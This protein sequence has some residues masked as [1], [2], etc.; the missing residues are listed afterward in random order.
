MPAK[1]DEFDRNAVIAIQGG[2]VY[3]LGLLGQLSALVERR[4]IVPLAL[5][6]TSA[7]AILATL[8]WAGLTPKEIR[9]R[10]VELAVDG[11]TRPGGRETLTDLLGP[12]EPARRPF[13]FAR[14]RALAGRIERLSGP[15]TAGRDPGEDRTPRTGVGRAAWAATRPIR[16]VRGVVARAARWSR[17]FFNLVAVLLAVWPHRK[18]HGLFSGARLE[19]VLD[20][21]IRSSPRLGN[22]RASLPAEGLLTFG[23]ISRLQREHPQDHDLYY[24]PLILTATNLTTGK[25][26]LINSFDDAFADVPIARAVRASAGFPLFFRPVAITRVAESGGMEQGWYVDGGVIANFPAWVFSTELRGRMNEIEAFSHLAGRPWLNIGL[27]QVD[28]PRPAR[29]ADTAPRGVLKSLLGLLTGRIRNEL[30]QTL[31]ARIPR[32]FPIEQFE[33]ETTGPKNLLDI[34]RLDEARIRAMF[35]RG[36]EV[37]E[38]KLADL[39]FGLPSGKEKRK[40][41]AALASLV[42]RAARVFG[43]PDN[44]VLRFRSNV[45]LPNRDRLILQYSYKMGHHGDRDLSFAHDTGLTGYCFRSRKPWVCNLG[46]LRQAVAK[47]PTAL[48]FGM[49]ADQHQR[50]PGDRTWLLS[51]PI[52]DTQDCWPERPPDRRRQPEPGATFIASELECPTD[53]AVFGVLNLDANFQREGIDDDTERMLTDARIQSTVLLAQAAAQEVGFVLADAFGSRKR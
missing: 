53:G 21:W 7:G 15:T 42:R 2:G 9:D 37:A 38:R 39:S 28:D 4:E 26:V 27:R 20:G 23:Q 16:A 12:F 45:F 11:P 36:E 10:F 52:F 29:P 47:D 5:S 8:Y 50:V 17:F 22:Y 3:G 46:L 43:H 34:D 40:I 48:W 19:A 30:E 24:P 44:G 33:S 41:E 31:A 6:G 13:D 1:P 49:T 35:H 18:H 25:L 32:S 14:F 51:V